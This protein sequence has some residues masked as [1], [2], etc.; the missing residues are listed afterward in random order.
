[1]L[2]KE[3]SKSIPDMHVPVRLTSTF[4]GIKVQQK[5]SGTP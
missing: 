4:K 2:L 3:Y 5:I 1:V